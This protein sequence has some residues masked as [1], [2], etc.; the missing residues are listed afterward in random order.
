MEFAQ[1]YS[2]V[3]TAMGTLAFLMLCQVL[4]V[5]VLGIR[6]NH[7]PGS[8]VPAD[9]G[10]LLFR[11][12][13]T[14]A[15]TNEIIAVFILAVSFCLFSAASPSLTA[16]AT[17]TFVAARFLFSLCYYSNLQRLRSTMFGVSLAALAALIFVGFSG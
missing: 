3:I 7:I 5:D 16:Y 4:V 6:A 14:V 10:N 8:Q 15:N 1:T 11:A 12:T 13:R 9:H 17:W 2:S